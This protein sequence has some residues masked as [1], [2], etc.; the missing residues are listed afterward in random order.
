MNE[1][2][3]VIPLSDSEFEYTR[4]LFD[5]DFTTNLSVVEVNLMVWNDHNP[6]LDPARLTDHSEEEPNDE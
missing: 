4:H 6:G 1:Y 5:D 2:F 3:D